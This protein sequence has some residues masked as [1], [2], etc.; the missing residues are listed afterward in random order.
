[1]KPRKMPLLFLGGLLL[2]NAITSWC[3]AEEKVPSSA[4]PPVYSV[5]YQPPLFQSEASDQPFRNTTEQIPRARLGNV[6]VTPEQDQSADSAFGQT[7]ESDTNSQIQRVSDLQNRLELPPLESSIFQEKSG[8]AVQ[9]SPITNFEEVLTG[10]RTANATDLETSAENSEAKT[11][12]DPKS[13]RKQ[14]NVWQWIATGCAFVFAILMT[15][16]LLKVTASSNRG[17]AADVFRVLG[18]RELDKK[19]TIHLVRC[20]QKILVIGSNSEGLETLAEITDPGEVEQ[21][22]ECCHPRSKNPIWKEGS[23]S[24]P[25]I[26]LSQNLKSRRKT[27][28]NESQYQKGQPEQ[29]TT[30]TSLPATNPLPQK[31]Q[32]S[33]PTAAPPSPHVAGPTGNSTSHESIAPSTTSIPVQPSVLGFPP[34]TGSV[35]SPVQLPSETNN[36]TNYPLPPS[37]PEAFSSSNQINTTDTT[38]CL[39]STIHPPVGDLTG[40]SQEYHPMTPDLQQVRTPPIPPELPPLLYYG[41]NPNPNESGSPYPGGSSSSPQNPGSSSGAA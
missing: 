30:T 1:M 11:V 34:D 32:T 2:S 35:Q 6:T 25:D 39:S 4:I 27:A 24:Q 36:P 23:N 15:R 33:N 31:S 9:K 10:Q 26:P 20:G 29:S 5:A 22:V 28:S 21:L 3:F 19:Q 12:S 14:T 7:S 40:L 8:P 41:Q 13:S 18:T 38:G 16:F 37:A 17:H